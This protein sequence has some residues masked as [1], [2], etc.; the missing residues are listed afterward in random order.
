MLL[1]PEADRKGFR[2]ALGTFPTGV[3]IVTTRSSD[4]T[5]TGVTCSSFNSVS[6]DPP[7]ILWSLD[8][9]A[10]SRP[11]FQAAEFWAVHVLAADQEAVSNQFARA[12]GDKFCGIKTEPGLGDIPLLI[13]CS[14]RFQCITEHAYEGG[15]HII[16]VGRVLD[17]DH[18]HR[19]PLLFH[20]GRYVR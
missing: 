11:I 15:D 9:K 14:T 6:L 19:A 17:F 20:S 5:Y 2:K 1:D 12:G 7:L 3:C 10:Y 4:G 16:F 18:T 13:D 8:K